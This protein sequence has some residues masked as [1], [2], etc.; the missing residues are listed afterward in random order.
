MTLKWNG[1]IHVEQLRAELAA[2]LE[3]QARTLTNYAK[4]QMSRAH[5]EQVVIS[6]STR[7]ARAA[8][9]LS[10]GFGFKGRVPA[11]ARGVMREMVG[12]MGGRHYYNDPSKPGEYPKR[13]TGLLRSMIIHDIDPA[14]LTAWWGLAANPDAIYGKFLEL[15]TGRMHSRPWMSLTNVQCRAEIKA[16]MERPLRSLAGTPLAGV[17]AETVSR[18]N[19][20]G[21]G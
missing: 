15:G 18:A 1:E 10:K 21:G 7:R 6:A 9:R 16:I 11:E 4:K 14:T 8:R 17:S 5:A 3:A 20:G 12:D 13:R 2:R 19:M